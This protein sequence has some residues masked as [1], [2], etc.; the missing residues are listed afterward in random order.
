MKE[1]APVILEELL[2]QVIFD[3]EDPRVLKLK[4]EREESE[5]IEREVF[6]RVF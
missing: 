5:R 2:H 1:S 6:E 3:G 4:A